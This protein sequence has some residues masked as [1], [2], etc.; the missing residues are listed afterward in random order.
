MAVWRG[1]VGETRALLRPR[2]IRTVPWGRGASGC[3]GGHEQAVGSGTWHRVGGQRPPAVPSRWGRLA[4]VRPGCPLNGRPCPATEMGTRVWKH[5]GRPLGQVGATCHRPPR[6]AALCLC[7][8]RPPAGR[9]PMSQPALAPHGGGL[10]HGP[11]PGAG[12]P[13]WFGHREAPCVPWCREGGV[14]VWRALDVPSGMAGQAPEVLSPWVP[15][16]CGPGVFGSGAA[17]GPRGHL[18]QPTRVGT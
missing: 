4:Y 17:P 8:G 9:S 15:C 6:H 1:Q 7:S 12:R 2:T 5:R 11:E 13:C 16:R 14:A 10:G 18:T 3:W